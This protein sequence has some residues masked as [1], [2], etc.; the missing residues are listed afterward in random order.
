MKTQQHS[1]FSPDL[2]MQVSR[3]GL[4][5]ASSL[6]EHNRSLPHGVS[7]RLRFAREKALTQARDARTAQLVPASGTQSVRA[8]SAL[9][10][11]GLNGSSQGW[12]KL[13]SFLPLLMLVAGLLLI[14]HSQW[15]EQI[16]ATA[17]IDTA[18]LSDHL[19]PAAY[20]DPGFSEYLVDE[21]E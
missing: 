10:L 9:A 17:E 12:F 20:G 16:T 5:V 1:H 4:R 19:P 15:Y 18:L 7:E 3:F 11:T 2:E 14:D 21:Q 6:S 8:G 13:A